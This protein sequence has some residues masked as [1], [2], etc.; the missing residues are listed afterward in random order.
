MQYM[1]KPGYIFFSMDP[2]VIM[3]ILGSSVAITLY[4]RKNQIGGMN[5]FVH[6]QLE[7]SI[8]PTALYAKPATVQL[9]RMFRKHG[10]EPGH[11]EAQIFGGAAPEG[12]DESLREIGRSNLREAEA[13]LQQYSIPVVGRDT[14]GTW[15]R[16][17]AFNT[18]TGE[19]IIAKVN[20]IRESDWFFNPG[21][22]V[23]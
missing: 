7:A 15:G 5:H 17:V 1:L 2:S 18:A 21:W 20:R 23:T 11:L 8:P 9:V 10:F 4:H 16:K 22:T 13:L 19:V 14:G 12:A 3:S 6:S